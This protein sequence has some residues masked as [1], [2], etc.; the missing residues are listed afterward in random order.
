MP[1]NYKRWMCEMCE[2]TET[3]ENENLI[4]AD[5]LINTFTDMA[6]RGTLLC[7]KNITQEDLLIQIIGT[8]VKVSMD[9]D[10]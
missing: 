5:K 7:G 6:N 3:S 8:I 1:T 9:S 10:S 2:M 4:S